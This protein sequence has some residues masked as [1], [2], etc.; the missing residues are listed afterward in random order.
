MSL[1]YLYIYICIYAAALQIM[2]FVICHHF[3]KAFAISDPVSG[4]VIHYSGMPLGF[5]ED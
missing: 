4:T 2:C 5:K 1:F 3:K